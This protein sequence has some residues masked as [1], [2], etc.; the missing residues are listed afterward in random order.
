MI[1]YGLIGC[2]RISY[3]HVQ[4]FADN[5]S[6]SRL[7]ACV[8]PII[9]LAQKQAQNYIDLMKKNHNIDVEVKVYSSY[10]DMFS[11]I[12][13]EID[14]ISIATESGYHYQHV[15]DSLKQNKHVVVEKPMALSI[16]HCDEM[17][18]LARENNLK[19]AV[20]HQ[21]R[22]NPPIQALRK[23]IEQGRFG[24][25][26]AGNAR[27]LWTR[28]ENY[29]KQAPWRGTYAMDG[30]CLMNQCIHN[31]D[32]LQWMLCGNVEK[33]NSMISNYN[34]DYIE[35]EDYGSIQIKFDNNTIGNVEGTVAVY[36]KNLEETLTILGEKGTVVIGGLAVNE[37]ET[38]DFE[39]G[40]DNLEQIKQ[41]TKSD[42]DNV[43]GN[44][45]SSLF[46][47]FNNSIINNTKPLIDGVE[48][49]KSVEIILNVYKQNGR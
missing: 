15:M 14:A 10:E 18:E 25:L 45:H 21:N 23:A 36:P 31:I 37:I 28:D 24:K 16:S 43:Y 35:A 4:A 8:D 38:W 32:L 20:S 12:N 34:H 3:K 2:G 19:L 30:G 47:D 49:K 33:I 46:E 41:Q 26:F 44:G 11:E 42:I 40:L 6:D 13:E 39:D 29:Y 22:F 1:K 17:I 5:A 9:E 27:I 7:I 48:G